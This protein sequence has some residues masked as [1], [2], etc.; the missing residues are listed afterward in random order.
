[1]RAIRL[2]IGQALLSRIAS[3]AELVA[4]NWWVFRMT[5]SSAMVGVVTLARL[6]PL[7][8]AGPRLGELADRREPMK[9]LAAVLGFGSVMTFACAA[10]VGVAQPG[11]RNGESWVCAVAALVTMR[12]AATSAEP[13]IR[14]AALARISGN[15]GLLQ[16]M[17]SLSLVLTASMVVGPAVTGLLMSVGGA[18]LALAACGGLYAIASA[19]SLAIASSKRAAVEARR[20]E[21]RSQLGHSPWR[22]A[23]HEV[24]RNPRLGAQLILAAGPMLCVFPYTAMLPVMADRV[25]G[26]GNASG[27]AMLSAASGVGAVAGASCLRFLLPSRP[28]YIAAV[29]APL[30]CVPTFVLAVSGQGAVFWGMTAIGAIGFVGQLYRTSNRAATLLLAP[31]DKRGLIAGIAQTDRVLIPAGSFL[32]GLIA[33]RG[34]VPAM[35]LAMTFGNLVLIGP[36]MAV[37]LI[38]WCRAVRSE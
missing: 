23:L 1:M 14:Q 15:S 31:E 33:D 26:T 8:V 35:A 18:G 2:L 3:A 34:G 6:L 9:L 29:A 17:S 5:E 21:L 12:S 10:A 19:L 22:L 7:L 27:I 38:S 16:S 30:L 20:G 24:R 25:F 36:P 13:A 37:L 32:L 28:V 4:L 11:T